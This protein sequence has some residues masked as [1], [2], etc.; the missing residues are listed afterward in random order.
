MIESKPKK[1]QTWSVY[2]LR[3]DGRCLYT[4]IAAD[5]ARRLAEHAAGSPKGARFTRGF[6]RLELVY[7]ACLG[8]RSLATRAE[9]RIKRLPRRRKEALVRKHPS[10]AELLE[11]L[12]LPRFEGLEDQEGRDA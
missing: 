8:D 6:T 12:E 1:K 11:L 2:I 4:G 10:P 9:A 7:Q 5:V 3:C